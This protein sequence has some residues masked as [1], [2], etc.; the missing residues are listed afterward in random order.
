MHG[1]YSCVCSDK[2][3][4]ASCN[5]YSSDVLNDY[6]AYNNLNYKC[7]NRGRCVFYGDHYKH[8]DFDVYFYCNVYSLICGYNHA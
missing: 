2:V 7:N 6:Y 1:G 4:D 3:Y 8:D 5:Y